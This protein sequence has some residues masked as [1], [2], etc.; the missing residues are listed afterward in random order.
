MEYEGAAAYRVTL[1]CRGYEGDPQVTKVS[2]V[3]MAADTAELLRRNLS[4]LD[5]NALQAVYSSPS[6][7]AATGDGPTYMF[8]FRSE[9]SEK[10]VLVDLV[11]LS[12]LP[13]PFHDFFATATNLR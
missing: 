13:S 8:V 11:K 6:E 3:Q 9:S 7:A 2:T 1:T 10:T 12:S 5:L 4:E